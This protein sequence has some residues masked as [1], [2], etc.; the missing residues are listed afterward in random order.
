MHDILTF[1][2]LWVNSA[3]GKL[4]MFL[5]FPQKMDFVIPCKLSESI[6]WEK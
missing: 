1:T 2:T 5:F 4:M 3:D 6:F